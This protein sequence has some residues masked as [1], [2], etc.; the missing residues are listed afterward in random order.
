MDIDIDLPSSFTAVK[1]F[2]TCV[3]ASMVVKDQLTSHPCGVYFQ[4]IPVDKITGFSAIPYKEAEDL[5]YT[6]IDF[7]HLTLLDSIKSKDEIRDL[8]RKTPDWEL[9][10]DDQCVQQL[11]QIHGHAKLLKQLKP[12]SV[13]ELADAIALIRPGKRHLIEQYKLNKQSVREQLYARPTE[14]VGSGSYYFK[15]SH[16]V[17]Y[18]LTIVV[19]LHLY[20]SRIKI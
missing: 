12:K 17:S 16:A 15:K 11:F 8:I 10:Q 13:I 9:L 7:L 20:A 6:K 19:Q 3:R 1:T 14:S 5:K 18:A 2:P 4:N